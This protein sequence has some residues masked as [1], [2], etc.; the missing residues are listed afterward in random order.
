VS[1]FDVG[2]GDAA[3]VDLPDGRAMLIDAGGNPSGGIDPGRA[4]LLPLLRA[5][6]RT[7]LDFVV[8]SHPHP[9]HY[10]GLAA[11]LEQLTFGEL[12][13]SGQAEPEH[14]L[15]PTA[16]EATNLLARARSQGIRIRKPP[17]L[18]GQT[19]QAGAATVR[20]LSPCPHYDSGYD[21]NDNSLVLRIDYRRRSVLFT[22]DA[23]EHAERRLVERG[24]PL[25]AE[26][27]KVGHHGSRTSSTSAFL[28]AVAPRLAVISAGA[29]NPF[30][31]PHREV[32]QRLRSHAR[33]SLL[34]ATSGGVIA[35]TD[36]GPWQVQTW[37]GQRLSLERR[38]QP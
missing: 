21:A 1:F 17:E 5:R 14:D 2:Q 37:A 23:E 28:R 26:I 24:A 7:Q 30:G 22:G 25:S 31:H 33:H 18:C 35:E 19:L 13:D 20:V 11:L 3:L 12:W 38:T 32:Q 15:S 10:G 4:A 9:D 29:H 34:L 6:R 8:L 27:L 16:A 36:G